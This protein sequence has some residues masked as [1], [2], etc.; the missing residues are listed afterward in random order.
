M[1][2]SV[3]GEDWKTVVKH[4]LL[5]PEKRYEKRSVLLFK[6]SLNSVTVFP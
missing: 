2:R 5:I 1:C 4:V 6:K 3:W